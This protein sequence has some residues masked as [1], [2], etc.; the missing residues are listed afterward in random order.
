M[1]GTTKSLG[2]GPDDPAANVVGGSRYHASLLRRFIGNLVFPIA[3]YN[4][5][6]GAVEQHLGVPQFPETQA[7]V[8][9]VLSEESSHLSGR[10]RSEGREP[11]RAA[12]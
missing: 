5:G 1:P 3:A 8:A 7:Y 2:V 12:P 6:S 4:A 10:I 9:G 11:D